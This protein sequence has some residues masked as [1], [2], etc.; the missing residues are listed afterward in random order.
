MQKMMSMFSSCRQLSRLPGTN[1]TVLIGDDT[2]LLVLLLHPTEM[3]AHEVFLKSEPKKSPQQNTIWCIRQSKQ[4]CG[5]DVYDHILFIQAI[6]GCV[7][8]PIACLD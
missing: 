8:K 7:M 4:L 3:D 2:D 1:E 5:P 6:L